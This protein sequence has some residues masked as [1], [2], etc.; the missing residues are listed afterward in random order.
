MPVLFQPATKEQG[1]MYILSKPA[2]FFACHSERS[3]KPP[4]FEGS[5]ATR[6][7]LLLS[8]PVLPTHTSN[9]FEI[10]TNSLQKIPLPKTDIPKPT[11]PTQS[12]TPCPQKHH[13]QTPFF[14][15]PPAKTPIHHAKK[16]PPQSNHG[17]TH[18]MTKNLPMAQCNPSLRQCSHLRIMRDHH[19]RVSIPMQIL[20]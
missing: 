17:P 8:L 6:V 20:Q 16:L 11:L 10:S 12:T 19:D 18:G 5:E 7:P 13:I 1:G 3:E 14:L 15:K 4:Y 2:V 9:Y